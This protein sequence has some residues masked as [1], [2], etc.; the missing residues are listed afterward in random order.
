MFIMNQHISIV[1][2]K[3]DDNKGDWGKDGWN[4]DGYDTAD[5]TASPSWKGDGGW[6]KGRF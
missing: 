3:I 5:P 6:D 1:K 4:D 2:C